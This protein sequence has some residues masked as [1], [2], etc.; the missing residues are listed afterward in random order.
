MVR[1]AERTGDMDNMLER[2]SRIY[3][4]ETEISLKWWSGAIE[5][6]MVVILSLIMAFILLAVLLP[7]IGMMSTIG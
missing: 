2:L 7:L 3:A 4:K 5:P 6:T 1:S